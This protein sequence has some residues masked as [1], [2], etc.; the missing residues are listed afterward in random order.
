[1]HV[2]G[3]LH[4]VGADHVV[5]EYHAVRRMAVAHEE[6]VGPDYGLL[7]VGR[8]E[9]HRRELADHRAI[10][11]LDVARGALLVL[12]VLRLHSDAGV[13]EYLAHRADR[14]VSVDD[15]ALA[16]NRSVAYLHVAPDVRVGS[17]LDVRAELR[18]VFD[19]RCGMNLHGIMNYG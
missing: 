19:Y 17:N 16:D 7:S 18:A 6:A 2:A 1:M 8:P 11:D 3:E 4:G 5:A 10:A 15:R 14:G 12:E 9:M 13:R